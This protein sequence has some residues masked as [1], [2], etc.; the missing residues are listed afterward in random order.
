MCCDKDEYCA[1]S[2]KD[3]GSGTPS[4]AR[5]ARRGNHSVF[6][7]SGARVLLP[8]GHPV[9]Q[10]WRRWGHGRASSAGVL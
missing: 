5:A 10:R 1:N 4:R 7:V 8:S 3:E 9:L 6:E 2:R